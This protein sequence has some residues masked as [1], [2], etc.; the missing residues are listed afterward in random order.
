[1]A[2][3]A[4]LAGRWQD[5]TLRQAARQAASDYGWGRVIEQFESEL[6]TARIA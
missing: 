1:V 3:A 2:Q 5:A 4:M 6:A